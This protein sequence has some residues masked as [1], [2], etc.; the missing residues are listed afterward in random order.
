MTPCVIIPRTM[1]EELPNQKPLRPCRIPYTN[2]DGSEINQ[3]LGEFDAN[4][5]FQGIKERIIVVVSNTNSPPLLGRTFL[6]AFNIK[7]SINTIQV[8]STLS[9]ITEQIKSEFSQVFDGKLGAFKFHKDEIFTALEG[10]ELSQ[11]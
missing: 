6:K 11:N 8:D 9:V 1:Y 2:F 4:I 7:L 10:G 3:I 5:T